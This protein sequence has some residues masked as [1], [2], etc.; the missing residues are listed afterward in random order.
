MEQKIKNMLLKLRNIDEAEINTKLFLKKEEVPSALKLDKA[1]EFIDRVLELAKRGDRIIVLGDYDCDGICGTITAVRMLKEIY[2]QFDQPENR[3][4]YYV[5]H[6]F[7]DGYGISEKIIDKIKKKN[8]KVKTI[9][10]VDNGIVAF[11]AIKYAKQQGFE[12]IITD[13]HK[14]E[15][16][17]PETDIIVNPNKV[18]DTYPFKGICGTTVIYKLL[19]QLATEEF[20]DILSKFEQYVDFVGL[21]T[22]SDVMPVLE[23]NRVYIKEAL[24]IFNGESKFRL[25]YGWLSIIQELLVRKRL[26][27][28]RVFTESDFGF[29]FA[30][31]INA[32][33]RVHGSA[34]VAIDTFLSL[35]TEDVREKANYLVAI[36]EKRKEE[37][38]IY[39]NEIMQTDYSN[40]S[41]VI[42]RNDN[43]GEGYIGL[44]AGKLAEHYN[45]PTLVLTKSGE[46]LK[47]SGRSGNIDVSIIDIFRKH[48]NLFEKLGGHNQALG[49]SIKE[50]NFKTLSTLL[51]KDFDEVIP[52][53][54]TNK[55]TPEII[56]DL[57]YFDENYIEKI[58][59]YAPF[60]QGFE[61][62]VFGIDNLNIDQVVFL[63]KSKQHLKILSDNLEI[64]VWNGVANLGD[65]AL[66]ATAFD[67]VGKPEINNFMGKRSIQII[68]SE[69]GL[70]FY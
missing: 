68:S 3:I 1:R 49:C 25:R 66:E 4:S 5:P 36:N 34:N 23:E 67:V 15:D 16:I 17:L 6:R 38:A 57:D 37:T 20:P 43:L 55:I 56:I 14:S 2:K 63:G 54:L 45:R 65:V 62:P 35:S 59:S 41:I 52:K 29:V 21:A 40:K 28:D 32:Q 18:G 24:Q 31:I 13:H 53:D 33:S 42:V 64:I 7:E 22:I 30:P 47:G 12:V 39:F 51:E 58:N 46:Y 27:K 11:D 60:G 8:P 9:I 69:N 26:S 48:Q 19:L 61:Y 10:T 44:I 50:E 70:N